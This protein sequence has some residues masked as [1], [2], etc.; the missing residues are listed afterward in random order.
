MGKGRWI[1][2]GAVTTLLVAPSAAHAASARVALSFEGI[3]TALWSV[4]GGEKCQRFGTGSQTVSFETARPVVVTL[5]EG[6]A[7]RTRI[8]TFRRAGSRR[9]A[10]FLV[11]PLRGMVKRI[12]STRFAPPSENGSPCPVRPKDCRTTALGDGGPEDERPEPP[13]VSLIGPG[14]RFLAFGLT[15]WDSD[16]GPWTNCLGF[17][18][19]VGTREDGG[20]IWRGPEFGDVMLEAGDDGRP[21]YR[22]PRVFPG[23]LRRGRTYR[24][25]AEARYKLS[26]PS[27]R[28]PRHVFSDNGIFDEGGYG[29]IVLVGGPI[30]VEHVV[31]WTV[32]LRRVG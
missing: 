5:G 23:R 18:T 20:P 22:P 25:I 8:L 28:Y 2:L 17:E 29:G 31:T 26:V 11:L 12:D 14:R 4:G 19:P 7:G 16:D 30:N 1:A 15:Y 27:S 10:R 6:R 3:D 9:A 13:D 21:A 32:T 24:F